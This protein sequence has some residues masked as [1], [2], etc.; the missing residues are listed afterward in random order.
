MGH[1]EQVVASQVEQVDLE[2]FCD[3]SPMSITPLEMSLLV[4]LDPQVGQVASL[5]LSETGLSSSNVLPHP[6]HMYS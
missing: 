6:S 4:L 3:S 5:S 2:P 1:V